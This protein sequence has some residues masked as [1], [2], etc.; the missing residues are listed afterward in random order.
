MTGGKLLVIALSLG[1][2][3]WS[4][5]AWACS[6]P[7]QYMLRKLAEIAAV[8]PTKPPLPPAAASGSDPAGSPRQ[9][10]QSG[11]Q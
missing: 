4:D 10:V 9:D 8:P 3:A 1:A 6:C 2:L 7:K 5:P 11:V